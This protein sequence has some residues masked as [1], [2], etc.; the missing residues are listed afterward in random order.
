MNQVKLEQLEREFIRLAKLMD[1]PVSLFPL[2]RKPESHDDWADY[3]YGEAGEFVFAQYEYGVLLENSVIL[4]TSAIDEMLYQ[5]FR[6]VSHEMAS[7]VAVPAGVEVRRVVWQRQ[8]ELLGKLSLVWQAR[9]EQ[10]LRLIL[11]KHPSKD[12]RASL[13]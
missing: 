6:S 1:V 9:L 3:I 8:L 4:R 12:G 7:Y 13:F 11:E 10:E 5:V 2:F